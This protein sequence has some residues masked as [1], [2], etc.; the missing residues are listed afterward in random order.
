MSRYTIAP[1]SSDVG[2]AFA[3]FFKGG[4]GPTHS[5]ISRVLVSAGYDDG[6]TW[7]GQAGGPNKEERVLKGFE[8][9]RRRQANARKF[10]EGLLS[11]LR[12]DTCIGS[13]DQGQSPEEQALRQALA[14]DGWYLTQEAE[15][16]QAGLVDF[17]TGGREAIEQQLGRIRRSANDSALLLGTSKE[18]LETAAKLVLVEFGYDRDEVRK[19]KFGRLMYLS[20]ERLGILPDRVD[21]NIT[22]HTHI[23]KLYQSIWTI[24]DEVNELRN[25]QGTGHGHD[26]PVG[27]SEDLARMIVIQT[28]IVAEFMLKTLDRQ[29][30]KLQ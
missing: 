24:I 19:M 7:T 5:V 30:G 8:T 21:P 17:E 23:R 14:R 29:M 9:A 22:G 1:I 4:S 20:R 11:A 6:Y 2:A 18:V 3:R 25:L 26:L 15:L 13:V 10:V 12:V 28:G 27:V 16:R